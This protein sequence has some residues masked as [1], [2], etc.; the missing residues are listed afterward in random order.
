MKLT[1]DIF[2]LAL[3]R[4]IA[5]ALEESNRLARQ[6]MEFE[7]PAFNPPKRKRAVISRRENENGEIPKISDLDSDR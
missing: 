5:K 6:R 4:R 2:E 3:L 1:R 7:F